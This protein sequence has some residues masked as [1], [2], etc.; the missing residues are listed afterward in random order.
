MAV[1]LFVHGVANRSGPQYDKDVKARGRRFGETSFAGV[2]LQIIDAYWGGFGANPKWD[3]ACIPNVRK[4]YQDLGLNEDLLDKE[5][6]HFVDDEVPHSTTIVNAARANLVATVAALSVE[7]LTTLQAADDEPALIEAEL[8]WAAAA[9]Y[10]ER[11]GA[12]DWLDEVADDGEFVSELRRQ[13]VPL[14][15]K[16]DLGVF[17]A[18]GGA[19]RRLGGA[20]SNLVNAPLARVG[21]ERA[22]PAL[23]IFLGDVFRYLRDAKP[24]ADIRKVVLDDLTA[25]ARA[26]KA[27]ST[28]LIVVG[29]S[30]GGIILYDL[31]TD[32][33]AMK[34]VEA[35]LKAP[36]LIDVLLTVGSQVALFEELNLYTSSE[37]DR[38]RQA[39]PPMNR[40]PRPARAKIWWNAFD[41]MDVLSFLAETVFDDVSDLEVDTIAGV[42]G[43]HT[44]YFTN[45]VF[46]QRLNA[47]LRKIGIVP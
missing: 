26:A 15:S 40:V 4:E 21:R 32:E 22:S 16:T 24:R 43:A 3:L 35:E 44:A 12:P 37:V 38:S 2:P 47:R 36:L 41:R 31:L 28:P 9:A 8:F 14:V 29:H 7:D 25:A 46:Y 42:A 19:V 10:S 33:T 30:M 23:A 18:I 11:V 45:M 13:V 5:A 17:D 34:A 27:S 6:A 20:L 1:L 39:A